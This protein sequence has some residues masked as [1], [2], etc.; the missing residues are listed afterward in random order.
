[1]VNNENIVHVSRYMHCVKKV[2]ISVCKIA[3]YTFP[4]KDAAIL[5]TGCVNCINF[6]Y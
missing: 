2:E 6:S 1:M 4:V 3:K 5:R